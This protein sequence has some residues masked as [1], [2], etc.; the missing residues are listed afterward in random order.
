MGIDVSLKNLNLLFKLTL[1]LL[2]ITFALFYRSIWYNALIILALLGVLNIQKIQIFKFRSM[3]YS[4]LTLLFFI[5]FFRSL[6]GYGKIVARLPLGLTIT[7]GGLIDAL[8]TV[9]QIVLIF[10]STGLALYSS[11]GKEVFYYF[12]AVF[13]GESRI[14]RWFA[15]WGRI[16][17][18]TFYFLPRMFDYGKSYQKKL[19]SNSPEGLRLQARLVNLLQAIGDYVVFVLHKAEESY[20]RFFSKNGSEEFRPVS[21]ISRPHLGYGALFI[22]LHGIVL[23]LGVR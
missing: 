12:N 23:T 21:L 9:E 10:L 11:S 7:S 14:A 5:F 18:F 16:G 2:L 6:S 15:S 22:L 17:L 1:A 8:F 19:K 13:R 3:A 20:P 4:L